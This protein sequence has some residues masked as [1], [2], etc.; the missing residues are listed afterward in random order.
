MIDPYTYLSQKFIHTSTV[1]K[2]HCIVGTHCYCKA[3][4]LEGLRSKVDQTTNLELD[5]LI[6][7]LKIS[8][9]ISEEA[10]LKTHNFEILVLIE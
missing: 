8:L 2:N 5:P 7:Q 6:L 9:I 10:K 4:T 3:A 1:D